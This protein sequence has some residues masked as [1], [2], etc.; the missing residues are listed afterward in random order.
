M[1]FSP[2]CRSK[3][4]GMI[5]TILGTFCLFFNWERADIQPE[6]RPR[7]IPDMLIYQTLCLVMTYIYLLF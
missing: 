3:K 2:K 7:E 6:I 4:L 5:Y 1:K